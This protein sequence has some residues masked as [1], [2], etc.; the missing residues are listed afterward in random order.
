ML[1]VP[2]IDHWWQTETR[3]GHRRHLR[4]IE[5]LTVKPGSPPCRP[6]AGTCSSSRP[7]RRNEARQIGALSVKPCL[8]A[9]QPFFP[10]LWN[11]DYRYRNAYS[12]TFPLLQT[13][14]DAGYV[15]MTLM[16]S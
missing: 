13:P 10:T 12:T 9:R 2:V 11:A 15:T 8:A 14:A 1:R 7:T 3:L 5:R 16:S 4:R 6:P